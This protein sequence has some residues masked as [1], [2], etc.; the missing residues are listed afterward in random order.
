MEQRA[1]EAVA[2]IAGEGRLEKRGDGAGGATT[3]GRGSAKGRDLGQLHGF[4][5]YFVEIHPFYKIEE[6]AGAKSWRCVFGGCVRGCWQ[7]CVE[8]AVHGKKKSN[9]RPALCVQPADKRK[10]S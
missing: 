8:I 9:R 6:T 1:W 5:L 3:R 4:S 2:L 7:L 10:R